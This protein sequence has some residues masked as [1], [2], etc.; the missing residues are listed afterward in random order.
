[1]LT[2]EQIDS[3]P[4]RVM[5]LFYRVEIDIITDMA[6]RISKTDFATD[7]AQWQLA[8]LE[9]MGVLEDEILRLLSET[10]EKS[11]NELIALFDEAATA[12]LAADDAVFIAAGYSPLPLKN[13]PFMQQI[14]WAGL[15]RT[16]GTFENLTKTTAN[17]A[18]RQF[19]NIL[20][21]AHLQVIS[22]AFSYQEAIKGGIKDLAQSGVASIIYPSGH[23]DYLD[24]AFRRATLTGVSQTACRVQERRLD[25]MDCDLVE[26]SAHAGAR[27]SHAA[28]QGKIYSRSGKNSKY[29]NFYTATGYGTGAGLGGWNCRHDFYPYIEGVSERLYSKEK[30]KAINNE[31]VAYNGKEIPLYE[32]TQKQRQIERNIRKWKRE[33]AAL[34]AAG[35]DSSFAESRVRQWQAVQRDFTAQTGLKRD[36][37][38]ERAGKQLDGKFGHKQ[39]AD[40]LPKQRESG[41]IKS[42][43][44]SGAHNP[45]SDEAEAHAIQYYAAVRAMKTDCKNIARNTGIP[46]EKIKEIKSF[47]FLEKHDLGN[48]RPEYFVP[49]YRMAETWRRLIEGKDIQPHDITLLRH[50]IMER[51]LIEQGFSQDEAHRITSKKYNYRKEAD[52]Y[53]AKIDKH[54]KK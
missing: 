37:F 12:T 13:N 20:D 10:T 48:E 43:A 31:T 7:T 17:T 8:K 2:P 32:A 54:K 39:A 11:R 29:R 53:Y 50:E 41:I 18:A 47:I 3:L 5:D 27:P 15:E 14:I 28:W 51:E 36:Y 4:N 52:A 46:E 25:E 35:E 26:V 24:V 30:L 19:E 42:G 9:Q 22:G 33:T 38:R 34:E 45:D 49:S 6:R 40:E 21:K 1:M 44:I 23:T 16:N